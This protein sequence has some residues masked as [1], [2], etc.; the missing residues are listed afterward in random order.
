VC[1]IYAAYVCRICIKRGLAMHPV[2]DS[3]EPENWR[4]D[5]C[6]RVV[7]QLRVLVEPGRFRFLCI[8]CYEADRR[9]RRRAADVSARW[10]A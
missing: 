4:C 7:D 8:P 1:S 5:S 2:H 10:R 3:P 9:K 6:D